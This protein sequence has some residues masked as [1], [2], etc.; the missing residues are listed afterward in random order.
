MRIISNALSIIRGEFIRIFA[1][2]FEHKRKVIGKGIRVYKN[3]QLT[4]RKSSR[5]RIGRNVKIDSDACL[6]AVG[7]GEIVIGDNV[8]IGSSNRVIAHERIEIGSNTILAPNVMLY[9]HDHVIDREKGV[10]RT[11]YNTG[12]ICIGENCWIGVNTVILRGTTIGDRCVVGAGC[13]LK[14]SYPAGSVI[15][16]KRETILRKNHGE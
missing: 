4:T 16:Q 14:G 1:I 5:I 3:V 2:S 11:E 15:I 9:D 13:I 10:R 8:G 7:K 6:S 12:A